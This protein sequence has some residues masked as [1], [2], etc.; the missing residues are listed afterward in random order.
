MS[1]KNAITEAYENSGQIQSNLNLQN[2]NMLNMSN[3]NQSQHKMKQNMGANN[4]I[5]NVE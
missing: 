5:S 4:N 2:Q 3:M 1:N